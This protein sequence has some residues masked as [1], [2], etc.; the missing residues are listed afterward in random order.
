MGNLTKA[1]PTP[2]L[3]GGLIVDDLKKHIWVVVVYVGITDQIENELE[4]IAEIGTLPYIGDIVNSG[5]WR[6]GNYLF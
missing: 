5:E 2:Y 3:P 4:V 1:N 6:W